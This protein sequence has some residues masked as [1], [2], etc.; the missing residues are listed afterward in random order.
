VKKST[1]SI[2]N[3]FFLIL[4]ILTNAWTWLPSFI[5]LIITSFGIFSQPVSGEDLRIVGLWFLLISSILLFSLGVVINAIAIFLKGR[6]SSKFFLF[7]MLIFIVLG[8]IINF[9]YFPYSPYQKIFYNDINNLGLSACEKIIHYPHRNEC[10]S[11]F[12]MNPSNASTCELLG[13]AGLKESCY[14]QLESETKEN[15]INKARYYELSSEELTLCSAMR[16]EIDQ[17]NC[18]QSIAAASRNVTICN[19]VTENKRNECQIEVE[20]WKNYKG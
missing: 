11:G 1:K 15:L 20:K 2:N 19:W 8:F 3:K 5:L 7:I 9:Y 16:K 12:A 17:D 14:D 4:L 10:Y 6:V 13:N 18:Y